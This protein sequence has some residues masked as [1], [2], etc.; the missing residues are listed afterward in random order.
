MTM[1]IFA[2]LPQKERIKDTIRIGPYFYKVIFRI[3]KW[4]CLKKI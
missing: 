1:I 3:G 4:H 2:T